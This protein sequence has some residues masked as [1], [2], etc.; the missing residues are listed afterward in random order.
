MRT[1]GLEEESPSLLA[2]PPGSRTVCLIASIGVS[3]C[4]GKLASLRYAGRS[5]TARTS[6]LIR[7]RKA[8][9]SPICRR[10]RRFREPGNVRIVHVASSM[11]V[12]PA[13]VEV[14]F[15]GSY[16]KQPDE[17]RYGRSRQG[18]AIYATGR[19]IGYAGRGIAADLLRKAGCA[20]TVA[21]EGP[22]AIIS[23]APRSRGRSAT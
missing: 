5:T 12:Q 4:C 10:S 21:P 23:A 1:I 7:R 19:P 9:V 3:V 18:V 22:E 11:I 2:E 16:Q 8:A 6:D 17:R 14:H 15:S 13:R 20:V